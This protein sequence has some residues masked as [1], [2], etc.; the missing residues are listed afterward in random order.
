MHRFPACII[1]S[2]VGGGGGGGGGGGVGVKI[3]RNRTKANR[4]INSKRIVMDAEFQTTKCDFQFPA[5]RVH[6]KQ[7]PY[8]EVN[9]EENQVLIDIIYNIK[10]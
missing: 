1:S 9:V 3:E 2:W 5:L 8:S 10:I 4:Q 6:H 7:T